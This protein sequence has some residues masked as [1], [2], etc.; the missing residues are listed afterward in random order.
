MTL[1]P[2][3]YMDNLIEPWAAPAILQEGIFAYPIQSD[4]PISWILHRYV[5]THSQA[6][7]RDGAAATELGVT[8]EPFQAWAARQRLPH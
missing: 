4:S 5:E 2:T 3:V 8:P 1:Q 7:K 6:L